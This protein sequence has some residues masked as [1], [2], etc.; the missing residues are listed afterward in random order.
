HT[1]A[2][3]P[4][5]DHLT[6]IMRPGV[7]V[8]QRAQQPH[9]PDH[10]LADFEPRLVDAFLQ[11]APLS[12]RD[13]ERIIAIAKRQRNRSILCAHGITIG[14]MAPSLTRATDICTLLPRS[15]VTE[16]SCSLAGIVQAL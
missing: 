7:A 11:L 13:P 5:A 2:D 9:W 15:A 3:Q 6:H 4:D 14:I 10:R 16:N 12:E 8:Q 1:A